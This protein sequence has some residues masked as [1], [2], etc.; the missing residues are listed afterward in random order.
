MLDPPGE[1]SPQHDGVGREAEHIPHDQLRPQRP[2][3][4]PKVTR[5]PEERVD[6]A[7]H[8]LVLRA[9]LMLHDVVE[10]LARLD[11][12]RAP[13]GLP[14]CDGRQAEE[15]DDGPAVQRRPCALGED[16]IGEEALEGGG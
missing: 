16:N 14:G 5:M 10:A 12:G 9:P 7:R 11:H 3:E 4:E 8:E 1:E 13:D 2:P 6:P 15:Y